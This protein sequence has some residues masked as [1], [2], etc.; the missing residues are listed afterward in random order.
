MLVDPQGG[1]GRLALVAG[2][3]TAA[4]ALGLLAGAPGWL[5]ALTGLVAGGALV[6]SLRP[7][8]SRGELPFEAGVRSRDE[9]AERP[10]VGAGW[11]SGGEVGSL[12]EALGEAVMLVDAEGVAVQANER[13]R[14][15]LEVQ[16]E[17]VGR[18]V[19][20]LITRAELLDEIAAARRG[21]QSRSTIRLPRSGGARTC[22]TVCSPIAP[23]TGASA[24]LVSIRDVTE[25]AQTARLRTDFVSN[26]SHELRTPISAI[27]A[28]ADTLSAAGS[29]EAMRER[30]IGMIQSH[31]SRLDEMVRDMLD[32]SKLE[33]A[34][35]A[36]SAR[37]VRLSE[38]AADLSDMFSDACALRGVG[39]LFELDPALEHL[40]TDRLLLM[41]IAKNLV[42][43][44]AK[45]AREGTD[46]R[47]VGEVV[48]TP[49][50]PMDTMRLRVIDRG[51]GIRLAEQQRI[52]E[53]FYQVD[54]ARSGSAERGSGLGL[55]IVK[56][57][58]K[59][60]EG[61][62]G[63]ESVWGQGTT[64]TTEIPSCVVRSPGLIS[65][66]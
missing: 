16:G 13:A 32:L 27:R 43:N 52:F 49:G 25:L 4:T 56:H 22:E 35:A 64:M 34:D 18:H 47:V 20:E 41:L 29:D 28:A 8:A 24:V 61:T 9:A 55:A 63:V 31:V 65:Q 3:P 23:G 2:V 17:I 15:L 57:A 46:I 60:L 33:S 44:A 51:V 39:L 40:M 10:G 59:L 5:V 66:D 26:A 6:W 14:R 21:A 36:V 7:W 11:L 12:V 62:V 48:A 54:P 1:W 37:P 50:A 58:A 42:E 45:F 53:R 30:L 19:E 38:L